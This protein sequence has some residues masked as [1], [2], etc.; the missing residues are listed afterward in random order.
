MRAAQSIRELE[1]D[2]AMH[3]GGENTSRSWHCNALESHTTSNWY[4]SIKSAYP[5]VIQW[6]ARSMVAT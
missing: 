2:L 4:E 1:G 6:M 3:G 5:S